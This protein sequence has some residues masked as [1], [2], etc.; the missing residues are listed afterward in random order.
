MHQWLTEPQQGA[1]TRR[2]EPLGST[3]FIRGY[4]DMTACTEFGLSHP[5]NT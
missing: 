5:S 2:R 1:S 4:S 3:M